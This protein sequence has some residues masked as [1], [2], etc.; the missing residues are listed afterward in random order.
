MLRGRNTTF[1][2]GRRALVGELMRT[3][4]LFRLD[5][6]KEKEKKIDVKADKKQVRSPW[7]IQWDRNHLET[8]GPRWLLKVP[9]DLCVE[10]QKERVGVGGV[11]TLSASAVET[12]HIRGKYWIRLI[13]LW[14]TSF[15]PPWS[16]FTLSTLWLPLVAFAA[17]LQ[18]PPKVYPLPKET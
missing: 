11:A 6:R 9:E 14:L 17:R 3:A 7:G 15:C 16:V 10:E 5:Y 8:R 1:Q 4:N 12:D 2:D 18:P 13:S